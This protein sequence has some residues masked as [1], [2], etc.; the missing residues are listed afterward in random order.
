MLTR[1]KVLLLMLKLARRPVRRVELM[2]WCF[3]LRHESRTAGGSAFYDFVPYKFG[4]FSFA[5]YQ[6]LEKLQSMS[7][8]LSYEDQEWRLNP[9]LASDI[10]GVGHAV[11]SDIRSIIR[12]F[13][14]LS[15][16]A[17]LDYVYQRH[18]EFTI[19]SERRRLAVR[20]KSD[21]AVYTAGYEGLSIDAFL[22]SLISNGIER[23]ID[24]RS[25]PTAR[26]YGFHKSTLMRLASRL[27][28]DYRH[29]AELGI[30]SEVR[31]QYPA[32]SDRVMMFDKYEDVILANQAKAVEAVAS[33][34]S[35]RASVLVCMEAEPKCCHRSRL[36]NPV[37]KITGLPI[38]HLRPI[39]E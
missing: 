27:D 1:Q 18:P 19:N 17:L 21:V 36:A 6:E 34:V 38:I 37:S 12:E 7:Y 16:E 39:H 25:N 5:M 20:P 23:L 29:F 14:R 22:N 15:N 28:I 8:I 35:E 32:D 3:L 10:A 26:R 33:L 4:P 24:V 9:D 11:E 30:Q 2:K 31:R 13:S